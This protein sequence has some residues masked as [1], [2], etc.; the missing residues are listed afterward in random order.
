[1]CQWNRAVIAALFGACVL[2][3]VVSAQSKSRHPKKAAP[4]SSISG[5]GLTISVDAEG[6][7]AISTDSSSAPVFRTNVEAQIDSKTVRASDYPR[8]E[9][10]KA[11]FTDELGAGSSLTI[12]HT[13]L[14][15]SPDLLTIVRV[16]RNRP[17]GDVD[18][19][20]RNSTDHVVSV[21]AIRSIQIENGSVV[22]LGAPASADRIL[23]DSYSE[24]RPQLAI[25]DLGAAPNGLHRA[26][27]SQLIYN[28]QSHESLFIGA[29]TSDK[30]LTIFHLR[31]QS[32]DQH[33]AIASY[34]VA[35][36]GT[37]EIMRGESLRHSPAA[38]QVDLSLPVQPGESIA[39]ERLMVAAGNNYHAQLE[40]YGRV[41]ARLHHARVTTPTP[42]GWW[43]WTA[44]YFGLSQAT[45]TTNMEW[46]AEHLKSRGFV[47][48]HMDEGYQYARGEYTTPD[49]NLF[50]RGLKPLATE[51][52]DR[53]LTFGVWT[54]P[55]EVSDRA[56]V[57]Q[58]HKDWLLHNAA[59][60][61]IH[62]GD[63]T[64]GKD[65]LY[66]LDLTNPGA[67]EYLRQTY[68]TLRNWGIRFIKMDF[69]DDSA[70]E[71]AY[72]R[73]HTTALEAQRI[74]LK[75]IREAVGNG[76]VLDKDGSPMLN[77]VGIVDAGRISQ[78]TGH[79]FEQ[80]S[81]AA[82]GIAARYY[83]NRNFFVAD[84]DAFNVSS[85]TSD[86]HAWRA[87]SRVLTLGEAKAS[88]ALSA[89]SG[90]MYEIGDDLPTLGE[91]PDRLALVENQDLL[92][93]VRLGR[94]STPIDLLTY[95]E[96]DEQPSEFLLKES[97]RQS[98]LT[99][100]NWTEK[101]LT[102]SISTADLGLPSG[103]SYTATD[104]LGDAACCT[105]A[106]SAIEVKQPAHSAAVI[107]IIDTTVTAVAP[108]FEIHA[109][110]TGQAGESLSF[111]AEPSSDVQPILNCHWDFGDGVSLDGLGTGHAYT[112]PGEY[113]AKATVT[114]ADGST[115]EK[116]FSVSIT[117][118][119]PTHFVPQ[120]KRRPE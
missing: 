97:P 35:S 46:L 88:I 80:T 101:G 119:I 4:L 81:E 62:I 84:P 93:M 13:G 34:E 66:V 114:G 53:G 91:S 8:H 108:P 103:H 21:E 71:G 96:S 45:A 56:Y 37:T 17:W 23:S 70:V 11:D 20:V 118:T 90:G 12:T 7:Y 27:G 9:V 82:S 3:S 85:Q 54:A 77:P 99:V 61:L 26:V 110:Q 28:K 24:D 117:G 65:P 14:K 60:D 6:A 43:S 15:A 74:G 16:Y 52:A 76:V 98:I 33:A 40:E 50:P 64:E 22:N 102:R 31:E 120:E 41:I 107:K 59:G 36:T 95:A 79:T 78:D 51:A 1:M 57:Y 2:S 113:Q 112:H 48:F 68:T 18:V 73:P 47:Y 105:V 75:I 38:E 72:Y 92:N 63:V 115:N 30:F 83:M 49:A 42:I 5:E 94:S 32:T 87:G 58:Q 25:Y 69:M 10:A 111:S 100:F 29:L 19:E 67:Q 109:P 86:D 104:V 89:V 39:S 44:Y 55:F 106:G 116:T